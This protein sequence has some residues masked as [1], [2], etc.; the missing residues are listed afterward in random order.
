MKINILINNRNKL[1]TKTIIYRI[2][3]ILKYLT[4]NFEECRIAGN[5][6]NK[7]IKLIATKS[8]VS[9]LIG[10]FISGKNFRNY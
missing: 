1:H 6:M 4:F 3:K 7:R 10:I 2:S 9:R 8:F 5:K